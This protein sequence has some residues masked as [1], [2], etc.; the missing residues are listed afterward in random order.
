MSHLHSFE[1]KFDPNA[2][3]EGKFSFRAYLTIILTLRANLTSTIND[4]QIYFISHSSGANLTQVI[5]AM[6]YLTPTI[7][8]LGKSIPIV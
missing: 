1:S 8:T 6:T 2:N 5:I 7:L 3:I 4:G